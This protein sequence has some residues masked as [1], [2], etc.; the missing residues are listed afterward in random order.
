MCS[1]DLAL[2]GRADYPVHVVGRVANLVTD[3]QVRDMVAAVRAERAIGA[4]L[5]DVATTPSGLW[6]ALDGVPVG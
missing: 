1:S 4:S 6:A 2:A 3:A 5:Y